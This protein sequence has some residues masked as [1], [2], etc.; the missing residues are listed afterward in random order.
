MTF[1]FARLPPQ[2]FEFERISAKFSSNRPRRNLNEECGSVDP[3]IGQEAFPSRR[4]DKPK[5]PLRSA[6][7]IVLEAQGIVLAEETFKVVGIESK[8]IK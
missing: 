5:L 2:D 7:K 3:K 6:G 8:G 4:N 1:C